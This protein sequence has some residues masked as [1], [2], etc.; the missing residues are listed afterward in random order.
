A[1]GDVEAAVAA[2]ERHRAANDKGLTGV[3]RLTCSQGLAGRLRRTPLID[4]FH[5]R[6][7][8]LRVELISSDRFLD[9]SK[10]E[11][12][13]AIR[14]GEPQDEA[15]VARKIADVCW[16]VYASRS[17]LERHGRPH[18]IEDLNNHIIL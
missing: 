3:L 13:I 4:D 12:D 16:A 6:Y 14:L 8:D 18:N 1:A 7:P 17:Y 9:L 15:L 5:A 2:F 10:G 11:A